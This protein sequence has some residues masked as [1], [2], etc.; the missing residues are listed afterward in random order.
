M[1][2]STPSVAHCSPVQRGDH[3]ER[4]LSFV[5]LDFRL[6][7]GLGFG[8]DPLREPAVPG[9]TRAVRRRHN[10]SPG[11]TGS[12]GARSGHRSAATRHPDAVSGG[13]AATAARPRRAFLNAPAVVAAALEQHTRA[14]VY[15]YDAMRRRYIERLELH[16][17]GNA[18]FAGRATRS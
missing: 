18:A 8:L 2:P 5:G 7:D 13:R 10:W 16:A 15:A 1:A 12:P 6:G 11:R 4:D 14:F 17:L 3:T 9:T